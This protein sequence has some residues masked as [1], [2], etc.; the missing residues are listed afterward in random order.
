[1]AGGKGAHKASK[2]IEA[3]EVADTCIREGVV[4]CDPEAVMEHKRSFWMQKWDP[5]QVEGDPTQPEW[6]KLLRRE[7]QKAARDKEPYEAEQ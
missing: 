6:M 4:T 1:M 2:L 5:E 7:A 3:D